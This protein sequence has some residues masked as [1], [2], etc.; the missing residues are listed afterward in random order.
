MRPTSSLLRPRNKDGDHAN[1]ESVNRDEEEGACHW[2]EHDIFYSCLAA[3]CKGQNRR[4]W[5]GVAD[6]SHKKMVLARIY[7]HWAL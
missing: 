2:L 3:G 5:T 4:G 6:V 1:I 7:C